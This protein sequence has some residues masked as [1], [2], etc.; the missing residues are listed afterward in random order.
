MFLSLSE[1]AAEAV[2]EGAL[3]GE[4]EA[5]AEALVD[6]AAL[7]P[8]RAEA[9]HAPRPERRR[10]AMQR[11]VG[12]RP[13]LGLRRER[14]LLGPSSAVRKHRDLRPRGRSLLALKRRDRKLLGQWRA[15][16]LELV[17]TQQS[18]RGRALSDLAR[19]LRRPE[20]LQ[21]VGASLLHRRAET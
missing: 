21:V 5:W 4:G 20:R 2:A 17:R 6:L 3:A 14:R 18:L 12:H 13:S 11:R 1:V 15:R 10:E 7:A 19:F 8:R 9:L 16:A